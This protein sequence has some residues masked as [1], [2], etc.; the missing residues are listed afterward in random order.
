MGEAHVKLDFVTGRNAGGKYICVLVC[1]LDGYTRILRKET[2]ACPLEAAR[3]LADGLIHDSGDL[4]GKADV[5]DQ[6][7]GQQGYRE[8]DGKF[9]LDAYKAVYRFSGPAD[10]TRTL[11]PEYRH[12]R[13]GVPRGPAADRKRHCRDGDY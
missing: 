13:D 12:D 10:D 1:S 11:R 3:A 6:L 4:F 5:G 8:A 9:H 2:H 7:H